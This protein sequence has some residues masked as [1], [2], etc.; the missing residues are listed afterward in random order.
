LIKVKVEAEVEKKSINHEGTQRMHKGSQ[1]KK[2]QVTN[3][4]WRLRVSRENKA[5]ST[6]PLL[7]KGRAGMG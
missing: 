2:E 3:P 7:F 4:S 6:I 1:R 5:E